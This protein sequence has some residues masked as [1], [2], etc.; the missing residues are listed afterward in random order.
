M[1][2]QIKISRYVCVCAFCV[3]DWEIE[4]QTHAGNG[5]GIPP[6]SGHSL[7]I[8]D[9]SGQIFSPPALAADEGLRV[10]RQGGENTARRLAAGHAGRRHRH[11]RPFFSAAL[12]EVS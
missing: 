10:K 3:S 7:S 5:V 1:T 9:Q 12:S 6:R 2:V 11:Q 4:L 8:I